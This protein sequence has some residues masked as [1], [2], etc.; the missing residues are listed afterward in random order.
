M[1]LI[2]QFGILLALCLVGEGVALVLPVP[3]PGSV[4]AMLFL[5]LL[6]STKLLREEAVAGA[7]DFLL[8][9][10][11]FFFLPAGV[12]ILAQFSAIRGTVWI[13]LFI[14][15]VTLV[16]T[17]AATAFTVRAVVALQNRLRGERQ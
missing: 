11:A 15:V 13:L 3:V 12:G 8:G 16:L 7:G 5:F 4:L 1:K 17:F 10:M 6:L 9:N 14:C 2:Q